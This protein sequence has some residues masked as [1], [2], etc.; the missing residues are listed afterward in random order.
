MAF[1][2]DMPAMEAPGNVVEPKHKG[3]AARFEKQ[4]EKG[5]YQHAK[6][7]QIPQ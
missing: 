3:H 6:R 4:F 5:A 2:G 7:S 1:I